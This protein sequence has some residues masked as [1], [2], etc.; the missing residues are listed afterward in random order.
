MIEFGSGRA[1]E[2]KD[3]PFILAVE[4]NFDNELRIVVALPVKGEKG[5]G[6]D[7]IED[8]KLKEIL[9]E[10]YPVYPDEN[11]RYEIVFPSYIVYQMR[12]E[13]YT[14]WDGD[15]LCEG[16]YFTIYKKSKLLD[17]VEKITIAR[18]FEDGSCYPEKWLHYGIHAQ[19][20]VLDVISSEKPVIKRL[21]P[22]ADPKS[23]IWRKWKSLWTSHAR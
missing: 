5:T 7:D 16:K 19:N 13:S 12:N 8:Q 18:Q 2:C 10:S 6:M 3:I 20:H 22:A 1:N 9:K 14:V 23:G 11:N 4:D 15:E 17:Q 21:K